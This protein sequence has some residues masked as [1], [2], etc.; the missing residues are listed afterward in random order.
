MALAAAAGVAAA[1]RHTAAGIDTS[2]DSWTTARYLDN[3]NAYL[4]LIEVEYRYSTG[5]DNEVQIIDNVVF[6]VDFI[7]LIT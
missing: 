3:H 6:N 7:A 4:Y 5:R 1:A 2:S